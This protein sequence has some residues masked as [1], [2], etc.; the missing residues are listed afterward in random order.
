[1]IVG[2]ATVVEETP[3]A[4]DSCDGHMQLR[5]RHETVYRYRRPVKLQSHRLM[6]LPRGSHDLR[7]L[8]SLLTIMPEAEVTWAQ[9]VFGNLIAT[10]NF[11]EPA[12]RLVITS[13]LTVEQRAPAWPVFRIAPDAHS[14]PFGYSVA[15]TTDLG[16]LLV[17]Q[18]ADEQAG[19]LDW[20]RAFVAGATTD[21][22]S[23]LKDINAGVRNSASYRVR[24]EAGTQTPLQTLSLASGSC[25][26]L[27]SLFIDAVRALGFG[28]RAVSGYLYDANA[29][30]DEDGSTH[31][32]AEVYLP[33]AGWIAFDPTHG[34]VGGANLV[35]VAVG[36]CN[37]QIMPVTGG[38]V[39][40]NGDFVGMDVQA[41]V[42]RLEQAE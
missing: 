28:A 16:A 30:L 42:V 1:M 20:A 13:E 19:I 37:A 9:D 41:H 14:Y 25:R 33:T 12:D 34:R 10:A 26:D 27:S 3:Q 21:T 11:V 6:L 5:L 2:T 23:L 7:V 24:D 29:A 17:P 36:R 40:A 31:A 38:Y 15:E 8:T 35:P 22:L 18:H 39:G 4:L 32:W